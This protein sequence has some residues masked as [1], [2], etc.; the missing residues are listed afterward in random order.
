MPKNI[1]IISLLFS[2]F[3]PNAHAGLLSKIFSQPSPTNRAWTQS[4]SW[5]MSDNPEIKKLA[6]EIVQGAQT[7]REKSF[8]IHQWIAKEIV[9]GYPLPGNTNPV[10]DVGVL[11][12]YRMGTCGGYA[13]LSASLQRAV[14]IPAKVVRGYANPEG[15]VKVDES[16]RHIWLE[17]YIDERWVIQDPTWDS[18]SEID[19]CTQQPILK[20]P[21][22]IYY[23]PKPEEF[24]VDHMKVEEFFL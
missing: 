12:K 2:L 21:R 6:K 13:A 14:G 1:L 18:L 20:D 19:T 10:N 8:R 4:S 3:S 24:S 11:L 7:D 9:Y 5:I 15:P 17:S 23:D 22:G 16:M